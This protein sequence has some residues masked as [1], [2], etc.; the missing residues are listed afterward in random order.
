MLHLA[1]DVIGIAAKLVQGSLVVAGQVRS[2]PVVA[3]V[4]LFRPDMY[5]GAAAQC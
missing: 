1:G 4:G 5:M 3:S 2:P